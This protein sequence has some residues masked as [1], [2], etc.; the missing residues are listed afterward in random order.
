MANAAEKLAREIADLKRRLNSLDRS[1]QLARSTI[2]IGE[3]DVGVPAALVAGVEAAVKVSE[4]DLLMKQLR[5]DL[6]NAAELIESSGVQLDGRLSEAEAALT[7]TGERLTSAEADLVEVFGKVENLSDPTEQIEAARVSAV[8]EAAAAAQVIADAAEAEAVAAAALAAQAAADAAEAAAISAAATDATQKAAKAKADALAEAA[9]DAT[10]KADAAKAAAN[11]AQEQAD[12]AHALAG[13]A[14]GNAQAALTAAGNAAT[15]AGLVS[16]NLFSTSSPSGTAPFGSTWFQVNGTGQVIGQWQ[17]TAAGIASTWT[18]RDVT[19]DTIANLDVGKLSAGTANLIAAVAQKIAAGTAD[20]QTVNASNLFVTGTANLN[21]AVV[22]K[23]WAEVVRAKMVVADEFIGTNAILSGAVKAA[24]LDGEAVNGKTITGATVQT[25][26]ATNRGVQFDNSGIQAWNSSGTR[27]VFVDAAT[28][29][30]IVGAGTFNGTV[31]ATGG[32]IAGDLIISGGGRLKSSASGN[33]VEVHTTGLSF[34]SASSGGNVTGLS[35]SPNTQIPTSPLLHIGSPGITV[36]S[37]YVNGVDGT[38][39]QFSVSLD[40]VELSTVFLDTVGL[41]ESNVRGNG[42]TRL[43]IPRRFETKTARDALAQ[44][45][46]QGDLVVI[47]QTQDRGLYMYDGINNDYTPLATDT[48]WIQITPTSGQAVSDNLLYY[49]R[50]GL[51]VYFK[52]RV[53]NAVVGSPI[54]TMP[55]GFI[56]DGG[57]DNVLILDQGGSARVNF[58]NNGQV[59]LLGAVSGFLTFAGTSYVAAAT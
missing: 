22:E 57:P 58:K 41:R 51:V 44:K 37:R 53:Q 38:K 11:T 35:S 27:T 40:T 7:S 52:G 6:D 59:I 48:D 55:A 17:Q 31:N 29:A 54:I 50:I 32:T 19:S 39:G 45:P 34:F 13:T 18:K 5:E 46:E 56:I 25:T 26:T 9:L 30:L 43:T 20:I 12:A 21:T 3:E 8:A 16:K 49:R 15:A 1:A 4:F 24:Q 42:G 14:E 36:G 23:I 47:A 28:G 2:R 10:G 33:R